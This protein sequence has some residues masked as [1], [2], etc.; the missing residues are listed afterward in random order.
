MSRSGPVFLSLRYTST[1]SGSVFEINCKSLEVQAVYQ[2]LPLPEDNTAKTLIGDSNARGRYAGIQC[3]SL[4]DGICATGSADGYIRLWP[5]DFQGP[6][7][8]A[9][10]L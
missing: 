5:L 7:M 4:N 3:L 1:S 9:G 6:F 2:L 8:E 10:V